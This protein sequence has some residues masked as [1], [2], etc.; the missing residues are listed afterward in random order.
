MRTHQPGPVARLFFYAELAS[1][2]S[3]PSPCTRSVSPQRFWELAK[4]IPVVDVRSP[5]EYK[6][7]HISRAINFP[8]FSDEERA[9]IGITYKQVGRQPAVLKGL[10]FIG[11]KLANLVANSLE[12]AVSGKVLVHCWRGG[13]RSQSFAQ[14]LELA[15]L[16]PT[17]LQGGYKSYRSMVHSSF[18]QP[19]KLMV[20]SGLTGAGKTDVLRVLASGSEQVVDLERLAN[21]RGSAFGGIGQLPQP[22]TEQFENDLFESFDQLDLNKPIWIE[23]E[24]NRV[25]SAILPTSLYRHLQRSPAV[26]IRCCF[27]QRVRNLMHDYGDLPPEQ[28]IVSIEKIRKRLGGL[29]VKQAV[30]AVEFGDIR[31]AIQIVLAYYDK[32]YHS[33]MET[34]PREKTLTLDTDNLSEEELLL[35]FRKIGQQVYESPQVSNL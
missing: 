9:E 2:N 30:A 14:I 1:M 8:L 26:A 33:A 7:G 23:D 20:V 22:T 25:G 32:T 4:E 34:M 13:M 28:L 24:G 31:E 18:D 12:V 10:K 17:V 15:G 35:S 6:Q 21:H 5:G 11:P 16:Q 27:D 29:A 3:S 19:M